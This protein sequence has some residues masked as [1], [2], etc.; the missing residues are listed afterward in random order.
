M[1]MGAGCISSGWR[2][3]RLP[4]EASPQLHQRFIFD[5]RVRRTL[6]LNVLGA[7]LRRKYYI[8]KNQNSANGDGGIGDVES[9]PR[10]ENAPRKEREPDFEEVGDGTVNDAIGEV[11]GG[12]AEQKR[13]ARGSQR[14]TAVA[15]DKQ[16]GEHADDHDGAGD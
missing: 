9:R 14:A 4:S 13:E 7:F 5:L 8:K 2:A 12:P 3:A 11:A 16:P 15:G 1:W 6:P 10:I